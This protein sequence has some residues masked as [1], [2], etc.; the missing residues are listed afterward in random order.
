MNLAKK[1]FVTCFL[2]AG[3]MACSSTEDEIDET[4]PVELT[5]ITEKFQPQVLWEASVDDGVGHYYS[6]LSPIVAYDK[7]FSASREGD[8]FAFDRVTGK[9]LWHADLRKENP[10]GGFWASKKP[11]LLAGGPVAGI[12]KV[13]IGSENGQV[14]ALS[15]DDGTIEWQAKIKGEVIASPA[16]DAGTLVVNSASGVIKAFN[17]SNGEELWSVE[18]EVPP[19]TLRGISAPAMAAGGVIIGSADGSL[20]VYI[21]DNGQQG[22][23]AEVGEATGSTELQR[24]IDIDSQ[25]LIYGDKVYAI[26]SRGHFVAVDL[27]SGRTLWKRQY[28]SFRKIAVSGNTLFITDVKGHVYAVDRINGLEKW[29]QLSLTNRGVTGAAVVNDYVVV[30]DYEG[31]L[32]WLDQETGEIVARHLVDGS[33][34]HSTPVVEDNVLYAQSRDGDLQAI[35]TP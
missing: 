6:R 24:V 32:H 5:E 12:N 19:L 14:V 18:Q 10:N 20:T 16:I 11:A 4:E 31:Y 29:S 27:R 25:P 13:F 8:A 26:S 33:G 21:V 15:A 17:A 7:V 22:W 1:L 35:K 34:I 9:E 2:T 23:T 30:G 3:L 28:S